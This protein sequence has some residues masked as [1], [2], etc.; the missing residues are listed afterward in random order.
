MKAEEKKLIIIDMH[1]NRKWKLKL[2]VASSY[3]SCWEMT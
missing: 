1:N 2:Y 3:D